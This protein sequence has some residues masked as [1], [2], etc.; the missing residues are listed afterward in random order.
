M[1]QQNAAHIKTRRKKRRVCGFCV[2]KFYAIDYKDVPRLRKYINDRGKIA[3][4]RNSGTCAK[5]QRILAMAVKR[6]R[7]MGL[8]PHCMD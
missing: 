3:P 6:A 7:F 2:D 8:V 4:R 1:E 5:H